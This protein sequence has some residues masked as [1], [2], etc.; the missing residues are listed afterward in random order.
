MGRQ[1]RT[2]IPML[3]SQLL[4]KLAYS[5]TIY[6]ANQKTKAE[7]KRAYDDYCE[8][9]LDL[10]HLR[11]GDPVQLKTDEENFWR[12]SG[13]VTSAD[14]LARSYLVQTPSSVLR[15][16]RKLKAQSHYHYL[17]NMCWASI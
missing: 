16:N 6:I 10:P 12:K 15:R 13:T 14:P 5:L 2:C 3:D 17:G 11:S 4:S 8:G 9:A 1:F 7:Y